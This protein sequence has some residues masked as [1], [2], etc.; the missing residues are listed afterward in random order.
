MSREW[1][2]KT[3]EDCEY[4]V[5]DKCRHSPVVPMKGMDYVGTY[6]EVRFLGVYQDACAQWREIGHEDDEINF[7]G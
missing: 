4:R 5:D 6:P 2:F 3:C 7:K 1:A